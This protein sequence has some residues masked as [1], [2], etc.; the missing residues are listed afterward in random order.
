MANKKAAEAAAP[1]CLHTGYVGRDTILM[2]SSISNNLAF[3]HQCAMKHPRHAIALAR[4]FVRT[5]PLRARHVH[6][7]HTHT[8]T[9][10][11]G[12]LCRVGSLCCGLPPGSMLLA[13]AAPKPLPFPAPA[14]PQ[15]MASP[16]KHEAVRPIT[17]Q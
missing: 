12:S 13:Q 10:T 7:T 3:T 11:D 1:V 9:V 15:Q 16:T 8:Q 17:E 14:A 6:H 4:V 5:A 2:C